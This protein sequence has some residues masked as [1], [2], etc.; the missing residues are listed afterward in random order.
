MAKKKSAKKSAATGTSQKGTKKKKGAAKGKTLTGRMGDMMESAGKG[1]AA[2][3]KYVTPSAGTGSKG[4]KK[5]AAKRK[6]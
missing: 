3:A 6:K 4:K 2:A 1:I 5:A